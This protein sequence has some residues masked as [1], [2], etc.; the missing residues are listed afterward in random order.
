MHG[1]SDGGSFGGSDGNR[2][3][4]GLCEKV[5]R[6]LLTMSTWQRS[7]GVPITTFLFAH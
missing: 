3:G 5:H 4:L 7:I 6:A 1:I 2:D